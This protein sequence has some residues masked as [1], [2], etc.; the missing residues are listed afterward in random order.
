MNRENAIRI[1]KEHLK[2]TRDFQATPPIKMFHI[3][4]FCQYLTMLLYMLIPMVKGI[5]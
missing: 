2:N 1:A 4:A 5:A 3:Q